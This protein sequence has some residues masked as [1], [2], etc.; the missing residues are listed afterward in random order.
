MLAFA[1]FDWQLDQTYTMTL[2]C[3]GGQITGSV[4]GVTLSAQGGALRGGG[5]GV[6]AEEGRV[7]VLSARVKPATTAANL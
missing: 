4:D 3:R 5:I 1:S 6:V 7:E 2:T